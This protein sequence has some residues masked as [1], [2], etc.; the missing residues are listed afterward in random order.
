[1]CE[2]FWW[3]IDWKLFVSSISDKEILSTLFSAPTVAEVFLDKYGGNAQVL[4]F[5]GS[6]DSTVKR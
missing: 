6:R 3:A 1:M 5:R 2:G 4:C